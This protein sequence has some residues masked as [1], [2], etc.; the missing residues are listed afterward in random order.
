[1]TIMPDSSSWSRYRAAFLALGGD[2]CRAGAAERRSQDQGAR[3]ACRRRE[4]RHAALRLPR[5]QERAR[6]LRHRPRAQDRREA[7]RAGRA[8]QGHLA[9]PHPAP[10]QRQ[11][12]S[13]RRLDD[14]YARAH[15]D[16]RFQHH[17]LYRRPIADGR[18]GEQ[19]SPASRISTASRSPCSRAR[20]SRRTSRRPRRSAK[21]TG[22]QGLQQ[23]L[24]RFGPG[25][26][27]RADRQPQ[28]PARLRQEQSE[29]QD[30]P[31]TC[32]ASS[33]SASACARAMRI[34]A[35]PST[36]RSRICGPRATI[37]SSTANGSAPTRHS[38]R[39][40]P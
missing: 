2:R 26:R 15:E 1:M 8:R 22:L 19:Q 40:R 36:S 29:F 16:D 7:R 28:H 33:P 18:Q 12:R 38:D 14:A 31:A 24:A 32:S 23:R 5:R 34:C 37:R 25:P 30:R 11:C 13:R 6:R 39:G 21:I 9:D 3:Q 17:L 4:I 20:R 10:G 35:T 27:R